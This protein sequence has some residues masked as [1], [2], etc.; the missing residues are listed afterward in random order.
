[1]S[2]SDISKITNKT[3]LQLIRSYS[4]VVGHTEENYD[5]YFT[6]ISN[7][8]QYK[9]FIKAG[10]PQQVNI[11][12]ELRN[13]MDVLAASSSPLK[14]R[15]MEPHIKA[16]R[17]EIKSLMATNTLAPGRFWA[18]RSGKAATVIL[19]L[20]LDGDKATDLFGGFMSY[21][22]A[23]TPV[24]KQKAYAE[25][26]AAATAA[27]KLNAAL[28]A[29]GVVP[30]AITAS[31]GKALLDKLELFAENFQKQ[32]TV[33]AAKDTTGGPTWQKVQQLSKAVP[34]AILP[35]LKQMEFAGGDRAK[36]E[37]SL[38]TMKA[39][40]DAIHTTEV[41]KYIKE[42]AAGGSKS[43]A[44]GIKGAVTTAK[45]QAAELARVKLCGLFMEQYKRIDLMVDRMDVDDLV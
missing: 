30:P 44:T 17:V 5:F 6:K 45:T 31:K 1:M 3:V 16:A 39:Q 18:D 41:E 32:V 7:E 33:V 24:D 27:S 8:Q 21:G 23:T 4:K 22:R 43:R 2:E 35:M 12:A 10:A 19:A 40:W 28:K 15:S 29:V 13:K 36:L 25:M 11:S 9:Q 37:R 26:L 20:G 42:H 34:A 14:Y 38:K